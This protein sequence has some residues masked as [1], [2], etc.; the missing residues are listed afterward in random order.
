MQR[1]MFQCLLGIACNDFVMI[2]ADQTNTQGIFI[3]KND[4]DKIIPLA[5]KLLMGVAGD[6]GDTAQFSHYILRNLSLYKMRNGYKLGTNAAVHFVRKNMADSLRTSPYLINLLVG[7]YDEIDGAKL[8]YVDLL[9][10]NI[11]MPYVAH[12]FGG[13]FSISMLDYYYKPT[14]T[15]SEA[16]NVLAQCV[17]EIHTRL[18]MNL[19]SFQVKVVNKKGVTTLPVICPATFYTKEVPTN[20]DTT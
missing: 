2:A 10:T 9:A 14:L 13:L 6:A 16:Y 1:A 7:G 8:Y 12:G 18:F 11:C 3:L 19:P 17:Y 15:E 4:E 20:S 5:D